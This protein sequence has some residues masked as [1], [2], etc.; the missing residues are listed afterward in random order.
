MQL[1]EITVRSTGSFEDDMEPRYVKADRKNSIST[2]L[3]GNFKAFLVLDITK[4][5]FRTKNKL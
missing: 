2:P 1:K 5:R 4:I 3:G